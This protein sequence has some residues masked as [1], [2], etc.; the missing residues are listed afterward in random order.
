MSLPKIA[1]DNADFDWYVTKRNRRAQSSKPSEEG[2]ASQS[3]RHRPYW[4]ARDERA[5]ISA[6]EGSGAW[7]K[8]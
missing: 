7:M 2:T 5:A 4:A 8:P 3:E 1:A 6:D